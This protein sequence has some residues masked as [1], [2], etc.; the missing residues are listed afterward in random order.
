MATGYYASKQIDPQSEIKPFFFLSLTLRY[1]LFDK[2]LSLT[3][4]ARNLLKTSAYDAVTI[5]N[6]FRSAMYVKSEIPVVSLNISYN[7]NNFKRPTKQAESVDVNY[8]M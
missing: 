1:D 2:K 6:N 4:Q 5:G 7:F 3:L 8:G